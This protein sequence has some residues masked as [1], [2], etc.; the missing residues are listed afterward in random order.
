MPEPTDSTPTTSSLK[1]RIAALASGQDT[2]LWAV[3]FIGVC[4]LTGMGKLDQEVLKCMVFALAGKAAMA[5][6][7]EP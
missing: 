3:G 6:R 7:K 2:V 5:A 1:A 4:V